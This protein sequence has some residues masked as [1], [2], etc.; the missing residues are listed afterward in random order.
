MIRIGGRQT[1][2]ALVSIL[3]RID[4]AE[5][6]QLE[7]VKVLGKIGDSQA[8]QALKRVANDKNIA[9]PIREA[10]ASSI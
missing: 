7:A 4:F 2:M 8:L 5:V 10:A 9:E 3:E 6:G 1:V